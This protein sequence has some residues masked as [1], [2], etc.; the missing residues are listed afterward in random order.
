MLLVFYESDFIFLNLCKRL[1]FK[2][3]IVTPENELT[4][5]EELYVKL[6]LSKR[7]A[8]HESGVF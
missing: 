7:I 3:N 1:K 4:Q 2:N 5:L 8:H 6:N